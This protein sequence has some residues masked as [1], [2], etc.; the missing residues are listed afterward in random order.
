VSLGRMR[1]DRT[2]EAEFVVGVPARGERFLVEFKVRGEGLNGPVTR[3]ATYNIL[4][5]GA[6][7]PERVVTNAAGEKVAEYAARRI[8]R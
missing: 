7:Q 2:R 8:E 5:D 1:P 4:P 6:Q 3:G